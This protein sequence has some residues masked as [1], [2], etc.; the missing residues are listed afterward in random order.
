MQAL[1]K[2]NNGSHG[3]PLEARNR[4]QIENKRNNP[5]YIRLR[6]SR[7]TMR[8][9]ATYACAIAILYFSDP[10]VPAFTVGCGLLL[11]AGALRIWSFGH[12]TKSQHLV[13]TGPYAHTRNPA[14][15]GSL[16]ALIGFGLAAGNPFTLPGRIVWGLTLF[17]IAIFFVI[18][19]PRKYS[20]EY[21]R[22]ERLFPNEYAEHAANV[23]DLLP[24]FSPWRSGD[25]RCFSWQ[26]VL[27]NH[28]LFW[29]ILVVL[30]VTAIW[31]I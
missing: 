14:Y 12:L 8:K 30:G 19:L 9:L 1:S 11:L 3:T 20:R 6:Q 27:D 23:P 29:P 4:P 2:P 5:W 15:L 17:F 7:L 10:W 24:R 13:T 18:Y 31:F 21:E 22:L 25:N 16:L 28:E 26:R